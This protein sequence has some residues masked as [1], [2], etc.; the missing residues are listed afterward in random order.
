MIDQYFPPS[1][2]FPEFTADALGPL[3]SGE[4]VLWQG[5]AGVAEY[6][7]D[8]HASLPRWTL[9]ETTTLMVTDQRA[10]YAHSVSD[11]PDDR[12]VASGELSW[13]WPQHVRVQP[14]AREAG[15]AAGVTQIQLVCGGS[16][17]SSPALVLAGGD[18]RTVT[19]ADRLA[20][21]LRQAIARFRVDHA[22]R[23]GL[24]SAQSRM[25][26]RLVIGPE[27]S[28]FQGGPG[29]TVS[30]QGALLVTPPAPA[31]P[32]PVAPDYPP[33]DH[34]QLD[35]ATPQYSSLD[36]PSLSYPGPADPLSDSPIAAALAAPTPAPVSPAPV[37]SP[38]HRA[39][40]PDPTPW[41]TSGPEPTHWAT[42]QPEPSQWSTTEPE[43]TQWTTTQPEPT[44]WT[45][46]EPELT[47]W[48][49]TETSAAT[50]PTAE[51]T[52]PATWPTTEPP[53]SW[54]MPSTATSPPT[55]HEPLP[56]VDAP[57]PGGSLSDSLRSTGPLPEASFARDSPLSDR[58]DSP[59]SD[60]QRDSPAH[61]DLPAQPGGEAT[62]VIRVRP[63]AAADMARALQAANAEAAAHETEPDLASRAADLAA[64]VANLV[65]QSAS[66]DGDPGA[67]DHAHRYRPLASY[68]DPAEAEDLAAADRFEAPTNDLTERAAALRRMEAR[69]AANSAGNKSAARRPERDFGATRGNRNP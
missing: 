22:D 18:L 27:F 69:F 37:I 67:A 13:L 68:L 60:D 19:D 3:Q 45:T 54:P 32:E 20:N 34:S 7:F 23:L 44:Q 31:P 17:G 12:A 48:S 15:R 29:E 6:A 36:Y 28:N 53:A 41:S 46:T 26:S 8:Q 55:A 35:Y 2:T 16:D 66:R 64:R 25:L 14:G 58:R 50:W 59:L 21:L 39:A 43:L 63:G 5:Q 47:Q 49:T 56:F 30:I 9:P 65:S 57:W 38:A 42:T 52:S 11:S 24:T 4:R 62:R 51:L 1:R 33:L 61:G 40:D 10:L